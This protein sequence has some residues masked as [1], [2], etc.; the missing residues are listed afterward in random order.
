VWESLR[1]RAAGRQRFSFLAEGRD[2]VRLPNL[3]ANNG[4]AGGGASLNATP[5]LQHPSALRGTRCYSD[6]RNLPNG[7][8]VASRSLG[9]GREMVE[10]SGQ[11]LPAAPTPTA[12]EIEASADPQEVPKALDQPFAIFVAASKPQAYSLNRDFSLRVLARHEPR[13]SAADH[14]I[15]WPS[16][17]PRPR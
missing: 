14:P 16:R 5:K 9:K 13:A 10:V 15:N 11:L 17:S 6:C 12:S 7:S 8:A 4:R 3:A 2:G 1:S